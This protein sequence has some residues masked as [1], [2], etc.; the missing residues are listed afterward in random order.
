[1]KCY[2][3]ALDSKGKPV[4]RMYNKGYHRSGMMGNPPAVQHITELVAWR[5]YL[6]E[7]IEAVD[8]ATRAA[9]EAKRLLGEAFEA[10]SSA[11]GIPEDYGRSPKSP[12]ESPGL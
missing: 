9:E 10:A 1:M 8:V 2:W 3:I 11:R 5:A 6:A 12:G 4:C 7:R